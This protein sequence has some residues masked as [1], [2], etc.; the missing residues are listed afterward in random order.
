LRIS[1]FEIALADFLSVVN[2]DFPELLVSIVFN[3]PLSILQSYKSAIESN[4]ALIFE[5]LKADGRKI[6]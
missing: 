4:F 3:T 2:Y 5:R 6:H 1:R